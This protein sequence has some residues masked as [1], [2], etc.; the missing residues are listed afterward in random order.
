MT[1]IKRLGKMRRGKR[2]TRASSVEKDIV[3]KSVVVEWPKA[4]VTTSLEDGEGTIFRW[5]YH[6]E[7]VAAVVARCMPLMIESVHMYINTKYTASHQLVA[8]MMNFV[9]EVDRWPPK[10]TLVNIPN[11]IQVHKTT[12]ARVESPRPRRAGFAPKIR[13]A[14]S[15]IPIALLSEC[16]PLNMV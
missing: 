9:K 3:P 16:R 6:C 12:T 4:A 5:K 7:T 1:L 11:H 13:E 15:R 14:N 8:S 2:I 10:K